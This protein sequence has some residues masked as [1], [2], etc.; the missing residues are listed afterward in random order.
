MSNVINHQF[1]DTPYGQ[2]SELYDRLREVI[3]DYAGEIPT[4]AAVGV[5]VMVQKHLI[6][7]NEA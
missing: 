7:E 5:L 1:S 3:N 4:A 6:E 2:L